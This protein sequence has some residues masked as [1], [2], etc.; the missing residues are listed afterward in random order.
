MS[1][2]GILARPH[3]KVN[4]WKCRSFISFSKLLVR[5]NEWP[6]A[7]CEILE[8]EDVNHP[9][10]NNSIR[11]LS[12]VRQVTLATIPMTPSSLSR[13]RNVNSGGRSYFLY[14]RW[15]WENLFNAW[16][17]DK[18]QLAWNRF[19]FPVGK[20]FSYWADI[21]ICT[22]TCI[23]G[24]LQYENL[25]KWVQL[26]NISQISLLLTSPLQTPDSPL[27]ISDWLIEILNTRK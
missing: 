11:E 14:S 7:P 20:I 15:R 18:L 5:S 12:S 8:L 22:V 24:K 13:L 27:Q 21:Y 17:L 6:S 4:M 2:C 10:S 23:L 26:E 9:V 16:L 1:V 25:H 3:Q 19:K